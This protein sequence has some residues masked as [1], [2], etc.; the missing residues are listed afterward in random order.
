MMF[1][2]ARAHLDLFK[3]FKIQTDTKT[4]VTQQ[5]NFYCLH[6]VS[7]TY[8]TAQATPAGNLLNTYIHK[9]LQHLW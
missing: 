2:E 8:C 5:H 3:E 4:T 6:Y 9:Q 1:H 7:Y